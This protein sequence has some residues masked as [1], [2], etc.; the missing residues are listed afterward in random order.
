M[1]R[2]AKTDAEKL[3]SSSDKIAPPI[4]VKGIDGTS[5]ECV[6]LGIGSHSRFQEGA[7]EPVTHSRR[8]LLSVPP[9]VEAE[10]ASQEARHSMSAEYRKTLRDRLTLRH[11]FSNVD[12]AFR[13]TPDGIEI[14]AAGP[15]E[16]AELRTNTTPEERRGVV[17]GLG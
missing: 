8:G 7:H 6:A 11:Y 3:P 15:T 12:V 2:S 17:Y 4:E 5:G 14:V 16:I 1:P 9:E 10:I 13:R